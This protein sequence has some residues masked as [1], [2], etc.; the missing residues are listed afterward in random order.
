MSVQI[1]FNFEDLIKNIATATKT[2]EDKIAK[3]F[4]SYFSEAKF[5]PKHAVDANEDKKAK[6][7]KTE[8]AKPVVKSD[9]DEESDNDVAPKEEK[10]K[11]GTAVPKKSPAPK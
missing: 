1:K 8:K 11:K 4:E 3:I 10:P 9:D 7:K 2:P 5:R 6:T